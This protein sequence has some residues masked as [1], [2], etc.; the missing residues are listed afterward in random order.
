MHMQ[1]TLE[2][3]ELAPIACGRASALLYP[4]LPSACLQGKSIQCLTPL[5][6]VCHSSRN[7]ACTSRTGGFFHRRPCA[8]TLISPSVH[9][10]HRSWTSKYAPTVFGP[11]KVHRP[12]GFRIL[13]KIRVHETDL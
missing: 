2:S 7:A 1:C 11:Q 9:I 8:S 5:T 12:S 10:S 3:P 4:A 13:A 6:G